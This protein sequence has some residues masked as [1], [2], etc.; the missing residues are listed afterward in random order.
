MTRS[1]TVDSTDTSSQPSAEAPTTKP[2]ALKKSAEVTPRRSSGAETTLQTMM[3]AT[4]VAAAITAT[5]LPLACGCPPPAA[6]GNPTQPP[7]VRGANATC[8][9]ARPLP[10]RLSGR[11]RREAAGTTTKTEET[12]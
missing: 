5:C 6:R 10:G 3:I 11:L 1:A 7:P 12:P 9:Q 4:I 2:A 8:S